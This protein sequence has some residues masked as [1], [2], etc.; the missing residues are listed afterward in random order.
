MSKHFT[1]PTFYHLPP[2]FTL[3]K[4]V[5][6]RTKQIDSW[7][8][9]ILKYCKHFGLQRLDLNEIESMELFNNRKIQRK[10]SI[11][12]VRIIIDS[13]V[14]KGNAKWADDTHIVALILWRTIPEWVTIVSK[15]VE[16]NRLSG[17]VMTVFELLN[18]EVST[19]SEF[20]GTDEAMF[21]EILELMS[22]QGKCALVKDSS[23]KLKAVKFA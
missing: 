4:V 1:F 10:L 6:V 11:S 14:E 16:T 20:V 17:S 9:L 13:L 8:D 18:K 3:Q 2:F 7:Q 19:H 22:S 5:S 12:T 21:S 23:G 15:W